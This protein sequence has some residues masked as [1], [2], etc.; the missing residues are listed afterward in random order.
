MGEVYFYHLTRQPL[1]AVVPMLLRKARGQGWKIAVRGVAAERMDWLDDKLWQDDGF[2]AHGKAGTGFDA[3]QPILL[4]QGEAANGAT[5]L[6][7]FDGAEVSGDEV[8][9]ME[10]VMIVFNGHDGEALETARAQWKALT[11]G[12]AKAQY[13]SQESGTWEMKAQ[14]PPT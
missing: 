4:T 9:T 12:G 13:W 5:C 7:S 11:G 10:R 1:E 2:L 8:A 14:H 6:V 3:D